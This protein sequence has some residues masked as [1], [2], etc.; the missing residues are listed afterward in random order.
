MDEKKV[1]G[2]I[3]ILI[4]IA[5]AFYGINELNSFSSK[6]LRMVGQSNTGA[7]A[8]VGVGIAAGI[9]GI[10]MLFHKQNTT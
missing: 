1:I 7:Y 5:I 3:L 10:V 6:M 8:A 2:G 9:A 4:G